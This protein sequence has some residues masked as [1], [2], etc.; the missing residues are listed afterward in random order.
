MFMRMW[1][2]PIDML[3]ASGCGEQLIRVE[4]DRAFLESKVFH[5]ITPF[6]VS[7]LPTPLIF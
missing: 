3:W 6:Y 2:L 5:A 1:A 7:A 4:D